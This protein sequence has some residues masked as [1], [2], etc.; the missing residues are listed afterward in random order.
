MN[1]KQDKQDRKRDDMNDNYHLDH[2]PACD[3]AY[4]VY[5]E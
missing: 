2:H 5:S 3:P 1:I 4:L